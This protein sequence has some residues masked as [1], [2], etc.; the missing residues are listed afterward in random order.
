MSLTF[1][2]KRVLITGGLGFIG[3]NLARRLVDDGAE[4]TLVDSLIPEYG[5][6]LFNVSDIQGRVRV[7]ISD[8]RDKFSFRHLVQGQDFLFNLAGQTSHLDSMADP[9]TDLE[10]N[11]RSQLSILEACR[12]ANPTIRIVFASTRQVYGRPEFLPVTESHPIRPVDVNGV[13]KVAGESFHLLYSDVYHIPT[14]VLR[15][16]NTY[17]PRMRIKDARQTFVGVWIR[18]ILEGQPFEVWEGDQLRDFTFVDDCVD[19]MIG[20]AENDSTIG[21]A[22]NVGGVEVV[23]L[24]QLAVQLIEAAGVGEYTIKQFPQDRKKIDIGDYYA[25]ASTLYEL[26]G[27]KSTTSLIEGLRATV[28]WFRPRLK[29]YID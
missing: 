18:R 8:V 6:N 1:L 20:A 3:S 24:K 13:N 12:E 23:S 28:D 25:D 19:A 29:H 4:I 16:T 26:T 11:C 2:N 7:N 17:G 14:T 10:I 22:L 27:W 15:L 5:G 21:K 9:F